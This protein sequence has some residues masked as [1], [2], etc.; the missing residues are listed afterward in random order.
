MG[1]CSRCGKKRQEYK[2][3]LCRKCYDAKKAEEE[4]IYKQEDEW[5]SFRKQY[6]YLAKRI[7]DIEEDNKELKEQVQKLE[8]Q[9]GGVSI[10]VAK[11][12]KDYY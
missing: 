3:F 5:E 2:S 1:C 9:L 8:D 7:I 12:S 6:P 10:L 4:R 11:S